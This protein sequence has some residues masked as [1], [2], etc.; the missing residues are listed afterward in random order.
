MVDRHVQPQRANIQQTGLKVV[1][2]LAAPDRN[3]KELD[4]PVVVADH[5]PRLDCALVRPR[6]VHRREHDRI[7]DRA[8]IEDVLALPEPAAK[9]T[10]WAARWS[11]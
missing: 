11:G 5:N 7:V 6:K 4:R 3:V 9:A 10:R 1:H 2:N 8:V